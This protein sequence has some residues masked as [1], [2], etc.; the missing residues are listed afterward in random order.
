MTENG[1]SHKYTTKYDPD[2]VDPLKEN[3]EK[4][5]LNVI[6]VPDD[7]TETNSENDTKKKGN[8]IKGNKRFASLS[9]YLTFNKSFLLFLPFDIGNYKRVMDHYEIS[10]KSK[11]PFCLLI[12]ICLILLIVIIFL[13][14]FWPRLPD[15]LTAE[16]CSETECFDS[17]SQVSAFY[18]TFFL[19]LSQ[20]L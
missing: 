16:V 4:K 17:S 15:Y 3:D 14:S 19:L 7:Q 13:I 12:S 20:A 11:K 2:E 6:N 10:K 9:L 8:N 18:W 5:Q 1:D